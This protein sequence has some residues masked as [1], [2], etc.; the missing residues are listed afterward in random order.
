MNPEHNFQV[1]IDLELFHILINVEA[2]AHESGI[3]PAEVNFWIASV[4]LTGHQ[5]IFSEYAKT[6]SE[7]YKSTN[8]ASVRDLEFEAHESSISDLNFM[9]LGRSSQWKEMHRS[10]YAHEFSRSLHLSLQ[11]N[12]DT[13]K[14]HQRQSVQIEKLNAEANALNLSR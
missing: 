5:S 14:H 4:N 7:Q 12:R 1:L 11:L 8:I 3:H 13:I 9:L 10:I 6:N 2:V